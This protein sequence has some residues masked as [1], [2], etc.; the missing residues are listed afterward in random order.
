MAAPLPTPVPNQ[1]LVGG[2]P[3]GGAALKKA[4]ETI[5]MPHVAEEVYHINLSLFFAGRAFGWSLADAAGEVMLG[6]ARAGVSIAGADGHGVR[7]V[8]GSWSPDS[9]EQAAPSS[10]NGFAFPASSP[11]TS[12]DRPSRA[13]SVEF[14]EPATGFV[15]D[16]SRKPANPSR[17][18]RIRGTGTSK[19]DA[20]VPGRGGTFSYLQYR[21][22]R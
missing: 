14:V 7:S 13:R 3:T 4:A 6:Q 5:G 9:P 15:E 22:H 21:Q 17:E 19:R 12:P 1:S 10:V 16:G 18:H 20:Y 8:A 11:E 2:L